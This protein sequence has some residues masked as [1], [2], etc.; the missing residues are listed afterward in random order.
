MHVISARICC[1]MK[2]KGEYTHIFWISPACPE[3]KKS[4]VHVNPQA[5][6]QWDSPHRQTRERML[7]M[8]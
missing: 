2:G 6:S 4:P 7:D 1:V 5:P 3:M 8:H